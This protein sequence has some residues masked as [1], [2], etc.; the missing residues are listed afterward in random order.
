MASKHLD[1]LTAFLRP[2]GGGVYV[3]ST[4]VAEQ[5]ALQQALYGA[6][7][8][9][10]IE[11][12]WRRALG[13]LH[14]ARVVVLGV[15]SDAGA[16]FTRGANRAPAALRA[17]LLRQPDHPLRAP[18]VVDVGD[19]RVIPHLLSEEMLS[20]AQIA[21]CRAALYGDPHRALPVSPLALAER[22][23]DALAVLAPGAVPVVLGG[24]HSVGW[25]A[26]AAAWRR[27]ER[28][29]GRRLGLLHFDAHTDLLPHRLG[30]R[31]CFA[32]W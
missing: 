12:A 32:T 4:G 1:E 19:V 8:P 7:R 24:D 15:P 13:R 9:D 27:H 20:P 25:P 5:Q 16:G 29:G 11:A 17:H 28:D 18:D 21:E 6:Q 30:V 22:A 23:L 31:Y 26:F 10:D 14:Q 3:V 2:A